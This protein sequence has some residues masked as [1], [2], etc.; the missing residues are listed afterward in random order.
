MILYVEYDIII[1]NNMILYV[2]HDYYV[3]DDRDIIII[4]IFNIVDIV[5]SLKFLIV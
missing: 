2:E 1:Y 5:M 3:D 4:T